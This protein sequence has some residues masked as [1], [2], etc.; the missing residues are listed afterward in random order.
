MSL[1]DLKISKS[2]TSLLTLL[3]LLIFLPF[4]IY[5]L[6]QFMS[7]YT[8]ANG[9]LANITVDPNSIINPINNTFYHSFAQGGEEQNNMLVNVSNNLKQL[10]PDEIRIDHIYDYYD[11][12]SKNTD[13]LTFNFSKLDLI[14]D[15]ILASGATPFFSL[16]YMPQVIAKDGNI[17]N[18]PYN[19]NDW[20]KVVQKTIEHFSGKNNRNL[21]NINYEVWNEPDLN[22]FGSWNIYGDKNYLTLYAYATSGAQKAGNCNQFF[23]GGPATTGLYKNWITALIKSGNRIDFF[24]WHT[25]QEDP[26][27]FRQDEQNLTFWLLANPQYLKLPRIISEFGPT[28]KK[29]PRYGTNYMAAYTASVVRQLINGSSNLFSFQIK[30]GPNETDNSGWGIFGHE[31]NNLTKKPRYYVYGFLDKMQGALI[32]LEG[33]GTWITGYATKTD[34]GIKI[35][36]INFD[37]NQSHIE[38]FPLKVINLAPGTYK[39]NVDYLFRGG[40]AIDMPLNN[41][42]LTE[43]ITDGIFQKSIC[44][45]YSNMAILQLIK[46]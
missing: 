29:D 32:K 15:S 44:L 7:L 31:N 42:F 3:V 38:S 37:L 22:Q 9:T 8:K 23:I 4:L 5:G 2:T 1:I 16:S 30:D 46:T 36:L 28:G 11:V 34:S 26:T 6:Y 33:E 14:V 27:Y 12:V 13:E 18:P 45:P 10:N 17:I 43:P 21:K 40:C 24:S 35:L 19:W 25:Y 20:E 39:W 41:G